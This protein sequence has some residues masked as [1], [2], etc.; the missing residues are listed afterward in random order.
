MT[1]QEV[2]RMPSNDLQLRKTPYTR[3]LQIVMSLD[4]TPIMTTRRGYPQHLPAFDYV[5][6]YI[7]LHFNPLRTCV[8]PQFS[9]ISYFSSISWQDKLRI[10]MIVIVWVSA[11][12][13]S[14]IDNI[15]FTTA[16]VR[17]ITTEL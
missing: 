12:V 17:R 9:Y 3:K 10:A 2:G 14:L 11:L 6:K 16:M 7:F 8:M 15:P 4:K 1:E 13:S 5:K